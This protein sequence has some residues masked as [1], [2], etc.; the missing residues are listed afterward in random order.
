MPNKLLKLR[1]FLTK[2]GL[3]DIQTFNCRNWV[4]D[5][6]TNI[7]NEDDIQVDICYK[8]KYLEIFGL[9]KEEYESLNDIL[10]IC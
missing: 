6:M 10:V 2:K 5:P 3:Q 8:Y 9:T 7:Y 1:D 4:G